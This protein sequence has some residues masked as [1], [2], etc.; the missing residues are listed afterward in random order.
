MS[1]YTIRVGALCVAALGVMLSVA[2]PVMKH[3]PS[4]P[5]VHYDPT[6]EQQAEA[7]IRADMIP[8]ITPDGTL[9]HVSRKEADELIKDCRKLGNV[10]FSD[11]TPNTLA[12]IDFCSQFR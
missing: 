10:R 11:M 5:P 8:V 2:L 7:K 9:K 3:S 6:P 4:R 12:A 1:K